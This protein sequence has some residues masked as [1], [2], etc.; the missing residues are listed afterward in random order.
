M[1]IDSDDTLHRSAISTLVKSLK[2]SKSDFAVCGYQR[3]RAGRTVN[4]GSWIVDA[5]KFGESRVSPSDRPSIMVNVVAWSKL[6]RRSFWN[7]ARLKF[8]VGKLYEDQV[9]AARAYSLAKSIDIIEQRFVNWRIRDEENS[10]ITQRAREVDNLRHQIAAWDDSLKV[11]QRLKGSEVA[12]IRRLQILQNDIPRLLPLNRESVTSEYLRTIADAVRRYLAHVTL[13]SDTDIWATVRLAYYLLQNRSYA[14]Y[15]R[16]MKWAQGS[17][18]DSAVKL[19]DSGETVLRLSPRFQRIADEANLDMRLPARARRGHVHVRSVVFSDHAIRIRAHARIA[20]VSSANNPPHYKATAVNARTGETVVVDARRV[21]DPSASVEGAIAQVPSVDS[22][23]ELVVDCRQL[24]S[25]GSWRLHLIISQGGYVFDAPVYGNTSFPVDRR[26]AI[27]YGDRAYDLRLSAKYGLAINVRPL[28]L[29][30][31]SV[32]RSALGDIAVL[33][34]GAQHAEKCLLRVE[35][36]KDSVFESDWMRF[37]GSDSDHV[38][39]IPAGFVEE[40]DRVRAINGASV[41]WADPSMGMTLS[42]VSQDGRS[43]PVG[44]PMEGTSNLGAYLAAERY[45]GRTA[46]IVALP[47]AISIDDVA[48][49]DDGSILI[50]GEY[51]PHFRNELSVIIEGQRIRSVARAVRDGER[52]RVKLDLSSDRW[53]SPLKALDPGA[54]T[55]QFADSDGDLFTR[56]DIAEHLADTFVV[57]PPLSPGAITFNSCR[58]QANLDVNSYLEPGDR[59][60]RNQ[61]RNISRYQKAIDTGVQQDAVLFR[62]YYGEKST[63]NA[64][65]I[66]E[67]LYRRGA[68][69]RLYWGVQSPAVA[70]PEGGIPVLIGTREWYEIFG[71]AG[72]YIDNVHQPDYSRKRPGQIFVETMHGYPFKEMGLSYWRHFGYSEQRIESFLRRSAEWDF[73][74]SPAPYATPLLRKEFGFDGETLE[75]GYPRNDRLVRGPK[76]GERQFLRGRLGIADDANVVLYAPTY[77]DASSTNEFQSTMNHFVDYADI[78]SAVSSNTVFLVRGHH[79]NA[80]VSTRLQSAPNVIDVTHYPE[81]GDLI[82][83]SDVAVL[84]YSSL[85]FDYALTGKPMVFLVP[86]LDEYL[87]GRSSL[88]P[89][90]NTAPGDIVTDRAELIEALVEIYNGR[91][92]HGQD[93]RAF[94][95]E[96]MPL[97]DGNASARFVDRVWGNL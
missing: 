37:E 83:A 59:G 62:S 65:A 75:I 97:E 11:Y 52:F 42:A 9:V 85:R 82:V 89:Y 7:S 39:K 56:L 12:N 87:A 93:R 76:V 69:L 68:D 3:Q 90:L 54:Y 91:D 18:H 95:K 26:L 84:D 13:D 51:P 49:A 33:L 70:V 64:L 35:I 24:T 45:R 61:Q 60:T 79:M 77:R 47:A 10:S 48:Q 32:A 6:Y 67:E 88:L 2:A 22:A 50:E 71:S 66:H 41:N 17:L 1:F 25:S 63:C 21:A 46:R 81:I 40:W 44:V 8:P 86:D 92:P 72:V 16:L 29:L 80:R 53:G 36:D 38:V 15:W 34:R 58:V 20:G 5:M 19:S 30:V 94:V 23:V 57:S 31:E 78:A 27:D 74:V 43:W 28:R 96:Y 4:P 55:L 73:F 14:E